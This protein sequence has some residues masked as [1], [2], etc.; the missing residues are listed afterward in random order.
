MPTWM[1]H[2]L[3]SRKINN[4]RYANDTTLK[5]ESKE[6]PK[7]VLIQVKEESKKLA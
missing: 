1:K 6:E 7:T 5:A 3:E 4:L 2:K